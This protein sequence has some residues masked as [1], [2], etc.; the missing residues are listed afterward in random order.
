MIIATLEGIKFMH[1]TQPELILELTPQGWG[2]IRRV[3]S[4]NLCYGHHAYRLTKAILM[5]VSALT[6][7]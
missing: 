7:G 2:K 1:R 6:I 5:D 3:L 4:T